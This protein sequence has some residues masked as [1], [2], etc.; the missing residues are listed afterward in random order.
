MGPTSE[1]ASELNTDAGLGGSFDCC[2]STSSGICQLFCGNTVELVES[3]PPRTRLCPDMTPCRGEATAGR[4]LA[5]QSQ[6]SGLG[7]GINVIPT[8]NDLKFSSDDTW[9]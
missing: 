4:K 9:T 1:L 2:T 6:L 8:G 5:P 3:S 7:L